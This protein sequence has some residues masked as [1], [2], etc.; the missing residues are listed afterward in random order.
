MLDVGAGLG[1]RNHTRLL[2]EGVCGEEEVLLDLL[3][4]AHELRGRD[5]VAQAPAGHRVRLREAV[6]HEGAP[7]EL[8]DREIRAAEVEA[9][10]D[11]VARDVDTGV[12][13]DL[14]QRAQVC[15]AENRAGRVAGRVDHDRLG[16]RPDGSANLVGAV[17]EAVLGTHGNQLGDA[18]EEGDVVGIRRI[19]GVGHDDLVARVEQRAK[20]QEHGRRGALRD[21]D[22][23]GIDVDPVVGAVPLGERVSQ[24]R[25]AERLRVVGAAIGHRGLGRARDDRRRREVGVADLKPHDVAAGRLELL[26]ACDQIHHDERADGLRAVRDVGQ[27]RLLGALCRIPARFVRRRGARRRCP[28]PRVYEDQHRLSEPSR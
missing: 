1:E 24:V 22:R 5:Q 15:L 14:G 26:G 12:L 18:A 10:V 7:G 13:G 19:A 25:V 6:E 23:L 16:P 21:D 20:E 3:G 11:L 8:Q 28:A 17:S 27:D 9:V 2:H 4:G